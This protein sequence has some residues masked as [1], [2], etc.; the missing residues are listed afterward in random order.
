[1]AD[2]V[3]TAAQIAPVY[4]GEAEI[5]TMIAGVAVTAGQA[6]YQVTTTGLLALSDGSGAG[7]ALCHG[8]ALETKGIG[9]AV[10][11]LKRGHVAGYTLAGN[12][13]SSA[14]LSDT[15]SGILADA[16]GTVSV[17]G[18]KVIALPDS[19]ATKVLYVNAL[20]W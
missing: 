18:G 10:S 13:G 12:Y 14:F 9:Q 17:V 1:M 6:V 8:I 5:Y 19:A 3:V 15:N 4:V 7:T 20:S 11:V 16:A 2:I